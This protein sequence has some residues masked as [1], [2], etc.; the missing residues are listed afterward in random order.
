ML[1]PPTMMQLKPQIERASARE[2]ALTETVDALR[3]Q[4]Q[5]LESVRAERDPQILRRPT[6]PRPQA[7]ARHKK[8]WIDVN[9]GAAVSGQGEQSFAFPMTLF[10]EP[11]GLASAYL[12]PSRGADFDFGGGYMFTPMFGAGLSI[13]GTADQDTVGLGA[14]IPHPTIFNATAT[15]VGVTNEELQ[16]TEG[17]ANFQFAVVPR[18]PFAKMTLRLFAGPTF[19]RL[20]RQMVE[21]VRFTQ[22]YALFTTAN[23]VT[24]TGWNGREVE[25]SGWGLHGGADLGY[26]FSRYAG[27][28]GTVRFS[29]GSVDIVEPLSE[30]LTAMT[31]G[32]MQFGGGL[33]LRF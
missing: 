8:V 15:G 24:I 33:R 13:T 5:V 2:Q 4:V 6:V 23:T 32:G 14:T 31:T 9:L 28:G 12:Q 18:L 20:K 26:F 29:R 30:T 1:I 3:A 19:F 16:R 27:V 7:L 22:Q 21:D 17:A 11:A 25:G 10:R